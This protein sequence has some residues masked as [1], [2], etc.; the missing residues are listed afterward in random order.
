MTEFETKV[1]QWLEQSNQRFDKI[2]ERFDRIDKRFDNLE[3]RAGRIEKSVAAL[4]QLVTM[5]D[6]LHTDYLVRKGLL[7]KEE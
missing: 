3:M 6:A 1:L 4:P 7:A 5:V 2:D